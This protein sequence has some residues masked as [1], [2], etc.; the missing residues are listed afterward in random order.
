MKG[1]HASALFMAACIAGVCIGLGLIYYFDLDEQIL[2]IL[3]WLEDQGWQA[4]L[5]FILIMAAAIICLAPGVIF[6]MGA[7][8]VF[9]VI[10][11]TVL[12]VAGTVLGAGIAFLIARYLFG[13]RP[14]EWV[15]SKVKPANIGDVIRDEGW[16]MIMYTRLVPLFPFKLSNYFFG[17]TPVRFR[18]FLLGNFLGVIPLTLTNVYVGS[19]ASDLTTLGSSEVERTPIEWALYGMGFVLA[20]VALVGLTRIARRALAPL[21]Q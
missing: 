15:M 7:G 13:K 10:K 17:L 4:S 14:S 12:V 21:K 2:E 8:F 11:G 16:Q 5:L 18:D 20:I 9:G 3:Q 6:T 19:I 1:K